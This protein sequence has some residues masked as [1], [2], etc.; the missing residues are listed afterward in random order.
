SGW[1]GG[2]DNSLTHL[3]IKPTHMIGGYGQLSWAFNYYGPTGSQRDE[4][5]VIR[6]RSQHGED[7]GA[8]PRR[9]PCAP[10]P[11]QPGGRDENHGPGRHGD[12]P[13]QVHRLPH[14][15]GDLQAGLDQPAGPGVRVLQQRGDQA[16]R[17]LPAPVRGPGTVARRMGTGPKGPAAAQGR[18]PGETAAVDLLEPGPAVDRRLWRPV[19]V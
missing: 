2:G 9:R 18:R 4:G 11:R 6:R 3:V 7:R 16:R 15:L 19:D 10:P 12:E 5:T 14:L 17:R 1:H 8:G 13:G